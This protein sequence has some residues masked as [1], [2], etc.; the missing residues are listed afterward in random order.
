MVS[1]SQKIVNP[2]KVR[3]NTTN[4]GSHQWAQIRCGRTGK[5][6]HTGQA[7][8]IQRV[9]LKRYGVKVEI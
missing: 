2:I 6:K 4:R 3:L 9:A 8:Y 1:V 7:K 5:V